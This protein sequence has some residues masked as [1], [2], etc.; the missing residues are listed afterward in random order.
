MGH[1]A[2]RRRRA[3]GC[4]RKIALALENRNALEPIGEGMRSQQ[5]ADSPANDHAVTL[6]VGTQILDYRSLRIDSFGDLIGN[7]P[8]ELRDSQPDLSFFS[9][10]R[11]HNRT[12]DVPI[13][14]ARQVMT[15][16][17]VVVMA[18]FFFL[19]VELV[20]VR[21]GLAAGD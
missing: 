20:N 1:A 2:A 3:R 16:V 15:V 7:A 10:N 19:D 11:T 18:V 9:V 13:V 14:W 5:A 17:D 21:T 12:Y 6:Y 8:E 4:I